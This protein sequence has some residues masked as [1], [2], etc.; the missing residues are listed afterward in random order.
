MPEKLNTDFIR[1]QDMVNAISD[2][3][4]FLQKS[5]IEERLTLMAIAYEI[6]IIGEAADK[7]SDKCRNQNNE[8]PWSDIIGMRHRI[9][10]GY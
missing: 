3:E 7:I 4:D 1:L 10:H 2:I 5:S 8:I 6:A 9:I